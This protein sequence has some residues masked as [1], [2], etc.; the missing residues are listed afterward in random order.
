MEHDVNMKVTCIAIRSSQEAGKAFYKA[1]CRFH[2]MINESKRHTLINSG[3]S[4]ELKG[5]MVKIKDLR[6]DGSKI[7]VEDIDKDSLKD[8]KR[9]AR[10]HGVAYAVEK[11]AAT[12]PPTFYIF[13]KAK[14]DSLIRKA[15]SSYVKDSENKKD[16]EKGLSE[17]LNIAKQRSGSPS[18]VRK[19]TQVR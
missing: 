11:D 13:F 19:K 7:E 4:S 14:D 9:Y 5:R 1:L 3:H 2:S 18:K 10:A 12:D 6:K 15:I 17:R 8:F 16:M